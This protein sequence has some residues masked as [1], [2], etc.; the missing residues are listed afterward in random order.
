MKID[1]VGIVT[2]VDRGERLMG[3]PGRGAVL[4]CR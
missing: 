1:G 4:A 3:G 2:C